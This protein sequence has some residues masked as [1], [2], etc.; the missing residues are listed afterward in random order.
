M[1]VTSVLCAIA[2]LA[3][4]ALAETG[5]SASACDLTGTWYGGSDVATP[6]LAAFTPADAGP[7]SPFGPDRYTVTFQLA[8][9]LS[10]LGLASWTSWFGEAV[11]TGPRRF[12]VFTIMY[13][14]MTPELAAESGVDGT[15]PELSAVH[16]VV[17][18]S[19]DCA[20]MTQTIDRYDDILAFDSS[21]MVPFETPPD[22]EW[23]SLIGAPIVET[24]RRMPTVLAA[25]QEAL[26]ATDTPRVPFLP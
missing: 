15:L 6:Y 5:R 24:Y 8:A 7:Y 12:E 1:K 19:G 22:F 21:V 18:L 9:N 14:V 10:S 11:R 20:S 23:I 2:L 16:G 26:R 13:I 3:C 4:P 25:P 17:E